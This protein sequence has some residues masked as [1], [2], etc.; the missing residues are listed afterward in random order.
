MKRLLKVTKTAQY[1]ICH[2]VFAISLNLFLLPYFI[3]Q[4]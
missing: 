1:V 4:R 3:K 2:L